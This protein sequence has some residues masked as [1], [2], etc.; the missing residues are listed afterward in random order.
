MAPVRGWAKRVEQ[1]LEGTEETPVHAWLAVV[2]NYERLLS[3]DFQGAR[4]WARRAIEI[5][6]KHAPAAAALGRVAEARSLILEGEV[7]QGIALLN[8]AGVATVRESSTPCR[9]ASFTASSSAGC[10]R[11]PSTTWP[12]SGRR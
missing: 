2:R 4:Q 8:E 5:G 3:G 6:G 7:A 1:L 11:W 12:K 10:R 9:R